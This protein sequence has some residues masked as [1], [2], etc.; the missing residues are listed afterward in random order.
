LR[1]QQPL[2]QEI[3]RLV[4]NPK[5]HYRVQKRPPLI[6]ILSQM[7]SVHTLLPYFPKLHS[8]IIFLSTPMVSE[9]SLPFRIS[10]QKFYEFFLSHACYIHLPSRP[11]DLITIIIFGKVLELI[12]QSSPVFICNISW[13]ATVYCGESLAPPQPPS[14]RTTPCRLSATAYSVYSWLPSISGGRLLHPLW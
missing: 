5:G 13:Q 1:S 4:W 6:L 14:C 12:M 10:N 9:W 7:L 8:N 2:S 11:P 3:S